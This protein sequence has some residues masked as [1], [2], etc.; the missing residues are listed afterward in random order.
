MS[1]KTQDHL[2]KSFDSKTAIIA[3]PP[4]PLPLASTLLFFLQIVWEQPNNK[5]DTPF[6]KPKLDTENSNH[7]KEKPPTNKKKKDNW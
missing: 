7:K 3:D 4:P 5:W 1:E 2:P 6:S